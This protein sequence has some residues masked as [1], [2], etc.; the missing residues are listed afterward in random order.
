MQRRCN[1]KNW[2]FK[3]IDLK[4]LVLKFFIT[5]IL[6]LILR[7]FDQNNQFCWFSHD[8]WAEVASYNDSLQK[9]LGILAEIFHHT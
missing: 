1:F 2:K 8:F 4:L 6:L 7:E 9:N 3:I 5:N